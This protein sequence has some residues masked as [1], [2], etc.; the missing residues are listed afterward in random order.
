MC[1]L[2]LKPFDIDF[3][4]LL[5]PVS[6]TPSPKAERLEYQASDLILSL[7]LSDPSPIPKI[8]EMAPAPGKIDGGQGQGDKI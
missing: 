5:R 7:V 8:T 2:F 4:S 3:S 1:F 6:V